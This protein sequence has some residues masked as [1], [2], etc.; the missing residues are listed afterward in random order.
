MRPSPRCFQ[1]IRDFEGCRLEAYQDVAGIWTVGYGQTGPGIV[2]G[3]RVSQGVA[4]AMLKD[5]LSHLGDDLFA[6][7]GW[8]L[9]QNQY[10][11]L[12]SFVYNVGL[13]A[14]K[15]STLL[16]KI[17]AYDI[18]GAAEEFLKWDHAGG[19]VVEGLTK[20]RQAERAL[21]LSA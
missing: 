18:P 20:R 7:V 19:K 16:K 13:H 6:L 3:T 10:D 14:F 4:N 12:I 21:F 15:G 11:A 1:L 5:T 17:L 8:R 2:E 9:N